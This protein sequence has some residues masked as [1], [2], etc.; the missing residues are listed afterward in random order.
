MVPPLITRGPPVDYPPV[1]IVPPLTTI[2]PTE[3]DY[4]SAI[5]ELLLMISMPVFPVDVPPLTI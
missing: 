1:V 5:T 2:V 4:P 3:D